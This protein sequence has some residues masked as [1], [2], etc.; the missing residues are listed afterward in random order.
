MG[1]YLAVVAGMAGLGLAANYV[2]AR[3]AA[4]IE[5]AGALRAESTVGRSAGPGQAARSS[6]AGDVHFVT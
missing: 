5:P 4:A 1:T 2:P 6:G 3:G